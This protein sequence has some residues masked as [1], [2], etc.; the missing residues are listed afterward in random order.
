MLIS[1]YLITKE[2]D[3]MAS[4]KSNCLC[5]LAI[6]AFLGIAYLFQFN[7]IGIVLGIIVGCIIF[8]IDYF[9][10][11]YRKGKIASAERKQKILICPR[12]MIP[13]DKESG[14]CPQCGQKL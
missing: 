1:I 6:L 10:F 13:V 12:C 14:I 9:I 2:G 8:F 3:C 5:I 11:F 7:T 4:W